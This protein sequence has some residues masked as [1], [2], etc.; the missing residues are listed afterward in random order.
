MDNKWT[1]WLYVGSDTPQGAALLAPERHMATKPQTGACS[2]WSPANWER[3]WIVI[4]LIIAGLAHGIN[5]FNYPTYLEDEG[6][7]MAQ[8]WAMMKEGHLDAYTYTYGHAPLGAMQIA[9]WTTLTGGFHTFGMAIH[10]GR[11]LMLLMQ[12]GST[13]MLYQI[14]RRIAQRVTVATITCLLFALSP[15][16]IYLHRRVLLDNIMTFWMLLSIMLLLSKRLSL[17]RIWLSATALG[18]SILSKE[19]S[20]FLIPVLIYLILLRAD[21]SHRWFAIVGWTTI[22]S[23]IVSMYVLMAVLKGELFPPGTLL[24]GN[25]P[26]VS[27]LGSLLWQAGREKDGGIL[28]LHSKFW[29]TADA[30]AKADPLLVAGGMFLAIIAAITLLTARHRSLF[31]VMG[32]ATLALWAFF[33]RGSIVLEFYIIPVLPL[34]ALN[35]ALAFGLATDGIKTLLAKYRRISWVAAGSAQVAMASF[36]LLGVIASYS[37]PILGLRREPLLLWKTSPAVIAQREALN[38]VKEHV[39]PCD[40]IIIDPYMWTD[41][42]DLPIPYQLAH[43]YWQAALDPAIRDRLFHNDWHNIDYVAAD[44]GLVADAHNYQLRLVEE[45]LAHATPVAR[46]DMSDWPVEIFQVNNGKEGRGLSCL[47][48]QADHDSSA[49]LLAISANSMRFGRNAPQRRY[50]W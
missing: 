4:I 23:A 33:V 13:C 18:I 28:S 35:I 24:G 12:V 16:G 8:A 19:V 37:S 40:S 14:A 49:T 15:Y 11:V 27:L 36:C 22:V 1:M 50:Q 34:L 46:F 21:R 20:T 2:R 47:A 7:Y 5:M 42:H 31:G 25:H 3:L 30:W 48:S 26:H 41:L 39:P 38:W 32:M 44:P 9:A 43:M 17:N 29:Q 45:A 6:I 10:S